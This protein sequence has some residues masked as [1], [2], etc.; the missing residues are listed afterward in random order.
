MW[1]FKKSTKHDVDHKKIFFFTP[2]K[3]L[4]GSGMIEEVHLNKCSATI[5]LAFSQCDKID[6]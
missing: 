2:E 5:C 6:W 3:M 4:P 1:I